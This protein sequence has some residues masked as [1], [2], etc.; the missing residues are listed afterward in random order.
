MKWE[1]FISLI[2]IF[3]KKIGLPGLSRSQIKD[4]YPNYPFPETFNDNGWW[5]KDAETL[6]NLKI[7]AEKVLMSLERRSEEDLFI[8]LV[9]HGAFISSF[10]CTLFNL[11]L[12][13]N[14]AFQSHNCSVSR[15]TFGKN[16][17]VT[18]QY[19][20]Y[21]NYLPDQLSVPRPKC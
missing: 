20:N 15:L 10:L 17:K 18:I 16:N 14:N 8:G 13:K 21:F 3:Q 11:D 4:A 7:R 6:P 9:T 2:L 1:E 19:L 5:N 12:A